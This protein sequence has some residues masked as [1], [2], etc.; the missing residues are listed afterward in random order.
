VCSSDLD[1]LGVL[2]YGHEKGAFWYGSTLSIEETRAL[3]PH[4][5]ATGLQVASAVIAGILYALAHPDEGLIETDAMDH[6]FCLAIQRP[7]LGTVS[8]HYTDWVPGH[9]AAA[10][11][12]QFSTIR[13]AKS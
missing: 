5:N 12:W 1:Q 13:R 11:P 3:A 6:A 7:Y 2:L 9:G 10:D 4:Q 8:G